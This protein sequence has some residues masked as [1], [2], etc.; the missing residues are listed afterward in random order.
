V[1]YDLESQS[2]ASWGHESCSHKLEVKGQSVVQKTDREQRTDRQTDA[3]R[4]ATLKSSFSQ[5]S[6]Y[7]IMLPP[8]V[9]ET[10]WWCNMSIS[11]S[12]RLSVCL[13]KVGIPRRRHRHGHPREDPRR[14]V[15][16]ARF[17]EI[18]PACGKLNDTPT[19]SRRS[20][21]GC[22]RGCQCRCRRRGMPA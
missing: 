15:R 6:V 16:H 4:S 1:T 10:K 14:H 19:F 12:V 21:R 7:L 22:R 3:D 20:S 8:T 2:N 9:E 11:P 13:S 18:I 17:P 5:H